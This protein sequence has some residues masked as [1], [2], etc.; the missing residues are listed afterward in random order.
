MEANVSDVMDEAD[1]TD[2][3]DGADVMGEENVSV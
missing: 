2:V 1:V 3:M